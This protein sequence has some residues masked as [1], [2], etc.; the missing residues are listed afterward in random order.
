MKHNKL[1]SY[2]LSTKVNLVQLSEKFE[3]QI[4][5]DISSFKFARN[6]IWIIMNGKQRRPLLSK[7]CAVPA[8]GY[9]LH[10]L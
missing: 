9:G 1:V 8:V 6:Q 3:H 10:N 4:I 7:S 5:S 2:S